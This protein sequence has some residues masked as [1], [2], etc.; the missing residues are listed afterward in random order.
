MLVDCIR[1]V[2]KLCTLSLILGKRRLALLHALTL[3]LLPGIADAAA[4]ADLIA[5]T[6]I[7]EP[8]ALPTT[9]IDNDT[10]VDIFDFSV[11]D[12]TSDSMPTGISQLIFH[13]SGTGDFS[14]L[15]FQL[16]GP[17]VNNV[18]GV[19]G[20]GTL[21]F[22][23][24]SISV[25][26]TGTQSYTI[27]AYYSDNTDHIEK[28]T[29]ILSIDGD[30]DSI[31]SGGTTMGVT[32]EIT[33]GTGTTVDVNAT[34]LV[35]STQPATMVEVLEGN[36]GPVVLQAQD[37]AGNIDVD[38]IE[39]ITLTAEELASESVAPGNLVTS[40]NGAS[41]AVA[42]V[43]GQVSWDHLSYDILS[44]INI[45]ANSISLNAESNDI[46]VI[47]NADGNLIAGAAVA[48]PVPIPTTA[49]IF[50]SAVDIFD[51][52]LVDGGTSDNQPMKITQIILNT[53]GNADFTKAVFLL[54]GPDV[55]NELGILDAGTLTF[56]DLNISIADGSSET[57][58]IK[59]FYSD[60][61][62]LTDGDTFIFSVNGASDVTTDA[63]TSMGGT[64]AITNG[65]GSPIDV[66]AS[67]LLF[68][69]QPA[70]SVAQGANMGP[71]TLQAQDAAGNI[72]R[73][74]TETVT[75]TDEIQNSE[76]DAA[77][78]F[79]TSS[80]GG[81]LAVPMSEGQVSW[82]NLTHSGAGNINIDANASSF[83]I[84]SILVTVTTPPPLSEEPFIEQG[85]SV[86]V[87]M[88]ED[89]TPTGFELLLSATDA[90]NDPL[91]WSIQTNAS[92]GTA[93]GAGTGSTQQIDYQPNANFNG[94]DSFIVK[95]A[96][97]QGFTDTITVNVNVNSQNDQPTVTSQ[98]LSTL[99]DNSVAVTLT[100]TDTDGDNLTFTFLK[101]PPN[102]I[103][104]GS[105]TQYIYT[106]KA[107][108]NGTDSFTFT[109]SDSSLSSEEATITIAV[110][111]VNDT[112]TATGQSLVTTEDMPL[113]I[114]LTGDDAD[115]DNLAYMINSQPANGTLSGA[116]PN[117][118]YR[119]NSDFSGTDSFTFQTSDGNLDS[120]VGTIVVSVTSENDVPVVTDLAVT[121][122][123]DNAV[124]LILSGSDIDG[125]PLTYSVSTKPAN[126]VLTGLPPDLTYHPDVNF[127]GTDSFTFKANDGTTDSNTAT[128]NLSVIGN[129]DPPTV[130]HMSFT[131]AEDKPLSIVLVA[132]DA[133]GD[134]LLFSV[135]SQPVNGL[136][137][138]SAPNLTYTPNADFNGSDSFTFI[139]TDGIIDSGVGVVHIAITSD[140]DAP[141]ANDLLLD[142]DGENNI[143]IRLTADDIDGDSLDFMVLNPPVEGELS[144]IA[145]DLTYTANGSF[146]GNDSFTFKANDGIED[147][148]TAIVTIRVSR[149]N[150]APV[151]INDE[152]EVNAGDSVTIAVLENDSDANGDPISLVSATVALG[153]L[154]ITEDSHLLY[155]TASNFVGDILAQYSISDGRGRHATADILIHVMPGDAG[156]G[157]PQLMIPDDI[158]VNAQGFL[159]EVELGTATAHDSNNKQLAVTL[160]RGDNLFTPGK[161]TVLWQAIDAAG[162]SQIASQVVSVNPLVNFSQNQ[163]VV[164]GQVA[165]FTIDLNGK[166]P[167]YP[168]TIP[169]AISGTTSSDDHDLINDQVKISSGTQAQ[170]EVMITDDGMPEE[171]EILQLQFDPQVNASDREMKI[172]ITD[173]NVQPTVTLEIHQNGQSRILLANH[174]GDVTV[175]ST[176]SDPNQDDTH[177]Y[178]WSGSSSELTDHDME[179]HSFT[180]DPHTLPED[181]YQI[182]LIVTDNGE[183]PLSDEV[184]R[185]I[186][187][188]SSLPALTGDDTDGDGLPDSE[189]GVGD[190]DG[191]GIADFL[192][193][194]AACNILV[195]QVHT[196]DRR[197]IEGASNGCLSLGLT[198]TAGESGGAIIGVEEIPDMDIP[199]DTE[200]LNV[201][202]IF[203]FIINQLADGV[204]YSLVIP[205]VKPIPG[206]A[207]YRKF[208]PDMGWV[209]F[210]ENENNF[211]FS[212]QGGSGH[213]PGLDSPLYQAGLTPGHWCV[214]LTLEDGGANDADGLR[215]GVIID[216]GGVAVQVSA[217]SAPV[218]VD[219]AVETVRNTSIAVD[220]LA[221]DSDPD[222]DPLTLVNASALFGDVAIINNTLTYT[223]PHGY[224]GDDQVSYVISDGNDAG[225]EGRLV[226]ATLVNRQPIVNHDSIETLE[227][228]NINIDVLANDSD[229]DNDPLTITTATAELGTVMITDTDI[230]EYTPPAAFV[231]TDTIEYSVSDGQDG[232]GQGTVTVNITMKPVIRGRGATFTLYWLL[233]LLGY[234]LVKR[235]R[236]M[237]LKSPH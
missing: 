163:R 48:E 211:I 109:A 132:N 235:S 118:T 29:F 25:P 228:T 203:D 24:L 143:G 147:S 47:R 173:N 119:P 227:D 80:N 131:T 232:S 72:D 39:I 201:G 124:T 4:N 139:A 126:G 77:G 182:K 10:V 87:I 234:S 75:L 55:F 230:L 217:N 82:A 229:P 167:F 64:T 137:S 5:N 86:I 219:D 69:S 11:A 42:A 179:Q 166:A 151:A 169:Y 6:T 49:T 66:I 33:N 22:S 138:G 108:F 44:D 157:F 183:P 175:T 207:I 187:I 155:Q 28:E 133:D 104:N 94:S 178:D 120:A 117:I 76:T 113:D 158:H 73:D 8:V 149:D 195:E 20:E 148:N 57:Y 96:D 215:N 181:S 99:E 212:A 13:T 3:M 226:V 204:S 156:T 206:N 52:D 88:D 197:L 123:E 176:L 129:N 59:A 205:Q 116:A 208:I 111:A 106:P 135:S 12:G 54:N 53:S 236:L 38:F 145:P 177:H 46:A 65:T 74:F 214:R 100:G 122:M 199:A 150:K 170:V 121:T 7:T 9:A 194:I 97:D 134:P 90:Q 237:A 26:D 192:D 107:N 70:T 23:D 202:G 209:N 110:A 189:E 220:V 174:E 115:Q 89:A 71:V 37:D 56:A 114:T 32:S 142:T 50:G 63:G 168:L 186:T 103:L 98:S 67:R 180:F 191:D 101:L 62:G 200:T 91:T 27:N 19:F 93:S 196:S 84:E 51:F 41:L 43:F 231:G 159:T 95:V 79:S 127:T 216:P 162:N 171:D 140:N 36:M 213:C 78:A 14:K 224:L 160:L 152:V 92:N 40:S 1:I 221:N 35:F 141:R 225:A 125:D 85:E 190:L 34:Q 222:N 18:V 112:P 61:S 45:D 31:S 198:A 102:G 172:T 16:N 146:S 128:V 218:T 223:P 153:S 154:T 2:I 136:L 83:N 17:N 30:I 164:E 185:Y 161:H 188:Q 81:N 144:G 165:V 193:N 210:V 184:I 58:T 68:T 233:L 21:T 130:D 15:V 105:G 60:N